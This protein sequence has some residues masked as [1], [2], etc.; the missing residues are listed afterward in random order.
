MKIIWHNQLP[1]E[2]FR[3]LKVVNV[4]HCDKLEFVFS[5]S[6]VGSFSQLQ[7]ME[8]SNCQV[9]SEIVSVLK[10]GKGEIEVND[11]STIVFAKLRSLRLWNL[12][13]L[14]GF[15]YDSESDVLFNEKVC[16]IYLF[17]PLIYLPQLMGF[18]YLPQLQA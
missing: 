6:M 2:S 12:P 5:S 17:C 15:Y 7:E 14:M 1:A 9:M 8:I 3:K 10:E 13:Q 16:F 18:Y 4:E 11:D